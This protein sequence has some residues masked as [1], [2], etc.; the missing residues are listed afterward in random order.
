MLRDR[1]N[2]S[3][4]G[5]QND[6]GFK[7]PNTIYEK[8]PLGGSKRWGHGAQIHGLENSPADRGDVWVCCQCLGANDINKPDDFCSGCGHIHCNECVLVCG[9]EF[10]TQIIE[11]EQDRVEDKD[12]LSVVPPTE[13]GIVGV[14]VWVCCH[15]SS[16]NEVCYFECAYCD[17]DACEDCVLGTYR[18]SEAHHLDRSKSHNS[19]PMM[20][21]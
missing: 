17:H 6:D 13:P 8:T 21:E 10:S 3:V 15:C 1:T 11:N 4:N 5:F 14:D 19:C 7:L 2:C 9:S 18:E 16:A 12:P 20:S